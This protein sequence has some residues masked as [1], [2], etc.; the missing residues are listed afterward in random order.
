MHIDFSATS[1]LTFQPKDTISKSPIAETLGH[2][3][4]CTSVSEILLQIIFIVLS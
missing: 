3:I 2:G 1:D 4:V